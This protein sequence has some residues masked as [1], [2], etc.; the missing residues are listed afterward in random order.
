MVGYLTDTDRVRTLASFAEQAETCLSQL[1]KGIQMKRTNIAILAIV[2]AST[3]AV[4]ATTPSRIR[5]AIA[6][7][8]PDKIIVHTTSGADLP[9]AL[10]A[11]TTYLQVVKSSLDKIEPGSYIGTATKSVGA[12]QVALEVVVFP[13]AMKGVGEG[14]FPWDEIPDTTSGKSYTSSSMTNG[15]VAAITSA[16]RP[17]VNSAMTNGNVSAASDQNGVKKLTVTYKGGQQTV[18]L[19]PT[20][21]VVTFR[22][23]TNSDL[24]EGAAVFIQATKNGDE[25]T[26]G[27]VVVEKDGVKPPM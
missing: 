10:D 5:G 22:P 1:Q 4:A 13:P 21:P 2:L 3:A 17:K 12:N 26:A 23:G 11:H 18:L 24:F 7:I 6:S 19:P 27:L 14:H 15:S 9:I 20:V 16:S 8:S 25:T